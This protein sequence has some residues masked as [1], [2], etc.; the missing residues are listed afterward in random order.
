MEIKKDK[1]I[2]ITGKDICKIVGTI[3]GL[4]FLF[5]LVKALFLNYVNLPILIV[6]ALSTLI[7]FWYGQ[8]K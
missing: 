4:S 3:A 2:I 7:L 1:N 6:S 5:W 8:K